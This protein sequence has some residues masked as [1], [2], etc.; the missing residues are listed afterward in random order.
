MVPYSGRLRPS[1][2]VSTGLPG[3]ILRDDRSREAFPTVGQQVGSM[4][5]THTDHFHVFLLGWVVLMV[6]GGAA[7]ALVKTP[8]KKLVL[9]RMQGILGGASLLCGAWWLS[10]ST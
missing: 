1:T 8:Y 3:E 6:C 10:A 4:F 2:M 7:L 5:D 9:T